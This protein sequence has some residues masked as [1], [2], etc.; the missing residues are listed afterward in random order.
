MSAMTISRLI[1]EKRVVV[2]CG[3]GGV[4]KTTVSAAMALAAARAGRRVLVITIDP[5]RRLAETLGVDRDLVEAVALSPERARAVGI[6]EPGRLSTWMLDPQRISNRV[7]KR[8]SSDPAKVQALLENRV[9]KNITAMIAGMQEYTAVEALHEFVTSGKYDLVILDTP[10]SRNALRFLDAPSRAGIFLDRR[11]FRLFVPGEANLIRQAASRIIEKVLDITLGE[12]ARKELQEFFQLFEGILL[13]LNRNQGEMKRFFA[14]DEISFVLVV[15][16]TQAAVEEA[17]Y[18]EQKTR[19]LELPLAGFVLNRSL[20]WASGRPMPSRSLLDDDASEVEVSAV[21]KMG[22][23]AKP[24]ND[25][26]MQHLKILE[27]L[28]QHSEGKGFA[29]VLPELP[30]E[31]SD[32]EALS[33]LAE[34]LSEERPQPK[35][36]PPRKRRSKPPMVS[37]KKAC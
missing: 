22:G 5:S 1:R 3:A 35:R 28:Q 19:E 27:D 17:F 15:S 13:H 31:A 36:K 32:L 20:A 23:L 4:G 11:I 26:I 25:Q 33:H 7:V 9:Y 37:A 2:C 29:W 12:G 6:E 30:A 34:H 21:R 14:G 10:P 8:L 16:P 24:E 18:F